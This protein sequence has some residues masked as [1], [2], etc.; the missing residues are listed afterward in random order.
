MSI[1]RRACQ[2]VFLFFVVWFLGACAATRVVKPLPKHA[3]ELGVSV[4]GPLVGFGGLIT[5]VPMFSVYGAHGFSDQFSGFAGVNLTSLSFGVGH[6]DL[7]GTYQILSQNGVIPGVSVSPVANV[8]LGGGEDLA[9]RFYPQLDAHAYW[10]YAQA[11]GMLYT[12]VSNWFELK[13]NTIH[14]LE[15]ETHWVPN[16]T[17]GTKWHRPKAQWTIETR[18][19]APNYKNNFVVVDYKGI[20]QKG[21]FGV[22]VGLTK[23]F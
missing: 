9:F 3:T 7:G 20:G 15:Q 12:G 19:L 13:Q 21:A 11:K 22:Y 8:M 16:F 14:G 10:D 6:L 5:P 2:F 17:L 4:G 18:Y 1:S 23:R